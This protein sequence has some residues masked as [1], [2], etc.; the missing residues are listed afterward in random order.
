MTG[1]HPREDE[2]VALV[3]AVYDAP[4]RAGGWEALIGRL[5][6]LVGAEVGGIHMYTRADLKSDEELSIESWSPDAKREYDE[7]FGW[8]DPVTP[9]AA[10][11][12]NGTT[13]TTAD[14]VEPREFER[15]EFCH[16]WCERHGLENLLAVKLDVGDEHLGSLGFHRS[17]RRRPFLPHEVAWLEPLGPHLERA[18]E[19]HVR[20]REAEA[21]RRS[22]EA[23]LDTLSVAV[24]L[25]NER[26]GIEA[27]NRRAR[28]LAAAGDG[29]A[30]GRGG[31]RAARPRDTRRLQQVVAEAVRTAGGRGLAGGGV[32]ALPRPSGRRSYAVSVVPLPRGT[33]ERLDA[34][35]AAAMLFVSEPDRRPERPEAWLRR[36]W[37]LTPAEARL[38]GR[39][40]QG[41][42]LREAADALGISV[43]T[44]R[45]QLKLVFSKT[46]TRRQADLVRVLLQ[47][48]PPLS[49]T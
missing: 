17:D 28:E 11:S 33:V 32:V 42:S 44:A 23:L 37:N 36:L 45:N 22:A 13:F 38:A 35:R 49:G 6:P 12:P 4:L 26:L 29:L 7:H 20:L 43:G 30:F 2:L 31:L 16:D 14:F 9:Q 10:Y 27:A 19:V 34:G 3:G 25:V 48:L 15:T 41:E 40:V 8:L 1:E 18:L 24:L 39:L 21:A 5:M 46:D 47:S